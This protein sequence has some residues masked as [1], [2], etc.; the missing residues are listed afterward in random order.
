MRKYL[1]DQ[2]AGEAFVTLRFAGRELQAQ[3]LDYNAV[4]GMKLAIPRSQSAR[5]LGEGSRL[6]VIYPEGNAVVAARWVAPDADR[7]VIG[8]EL[9]DGGYAGMILLRWYESPPHAARIERAARR[10]R[11]YIAE[12]PEALAELPAR[13]FEENVSEIWRQCGFEVELALPT[14]D[15]RHGLLAVGVSDDEGREKYIIECK[16]NLDDREVEVGLVLYLFTVQQLT[17]TNIAVLATTSYFNEPKWK[18]QKSGSVW[19]LELADYEAIVRWL[20]EYRKLREEAGR[21]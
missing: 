19:N 7:T 12:R 20:Q 5:I 11:Q 17:E 13:R 8:V 21:E 1:R 4:G 18:L 10:T 16:K 15:R 3:L 2:P 9:V 14:R 6:A